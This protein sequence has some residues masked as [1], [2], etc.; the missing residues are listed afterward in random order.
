MGRAAFWNGPD[1]QGGTKQETDGREGQAFFY[2]ARIDPMPVKP[3]WRPALACSRSTP[4]SS[5]WP[6]FPK[7]L[8]ITKPPS[9]A[10]RLAWIPCPGEPL[11]TPLRPTPAH[12]LSVFP[13]RDRG[14]GEPL[15]YTHPAGRH[16]RYSRPRALTSPLT[17]AHL[18]HILTRPS[19]AGVPTD[20]LTLSLMRCPSPCLIY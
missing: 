9:T 10:S 4:P 20:K 8:I 3:T 14:L 16:D 7:L 5:A 19:L 12:L 18:F 13:S 17:P 6:V 1:A 15:T 11:E 2:P